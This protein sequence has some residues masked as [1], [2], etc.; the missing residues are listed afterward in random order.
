MLFDIP[1]ELIP[2][3]LQALLDVELGH[4]NTYQEV[5]LIATPFSIALLL[6]GSAPTYFLTSAIK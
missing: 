3:E 1:D 6:H 5:A 4:M 2:R